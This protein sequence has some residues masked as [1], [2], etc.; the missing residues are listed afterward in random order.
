MTQYSAFSTDVRCELIKKG[1]TFADL[2]SAVSEKTGLYC[3]GPYIS[4]ILAEERKPQKILSAI[5][6][7]LDLP[8]RREDSA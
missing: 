7:I 6:E 3:D 5:R 8:E 2:A 4:R 1:W